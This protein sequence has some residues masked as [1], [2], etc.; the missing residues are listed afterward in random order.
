[1]QVLRSPL[2][3]TR[4]QRDP[5]H[6]VQLHTVPKPTIS[7]DKRSSVTTK[8]GGSHATNAMWLLQYALSHP[9]TNLMTFTPPSSSSSSSSQSAVVRM[10][11]ADAERVAHY[12]IAAG[13]R[14]VLKPRRRRGVALCGSAQD[15]TSP[16]SGRALLLMLRQVIE[17]FRTL[18]C[19]HPGGW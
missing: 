4:Y 3:S 7:H 17:G 6:T 11:A 15:A 14:A 13:G 10:S 2:A 5:R 18:L 8:V 9:H 16:A 19:R 12:T 1:M